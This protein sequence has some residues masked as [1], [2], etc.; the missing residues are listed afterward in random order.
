ML[1]EPQTLAYAEQSTP[2][3]RA[4]LHVGAVHATQIL[5]GDP[6]LRDHDARV[7]SGEHPITRK[8]QIAI[9]RPS[10]GEGTCGERNSEIGSL[11]VVV[12]DHVLCNVPLCK[13]CA[14]CKPQKWAAYIEY[15]N[16]H[17]SATKSSLDHSWEWS[18]QVV[19]AN[20]R[21]NPKGFAEYGDFIGVGS[22]PVL[23]LHIWIA[24]GYHFRE[25]QHDLALF[26]GCVVLHSPI[27]HNGT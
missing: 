13:R 8:A 25:P 6:F 16:L 22:E 7:L 5:D 26:V 27:H 2:P 4:T 10:D 11:E 17:R 24:L 14:Q 15:T 3:D 19:A 20:Q 9:R 1:P 23:G 21:E 18:Q 12:V